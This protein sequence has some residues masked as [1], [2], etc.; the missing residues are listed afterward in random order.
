MVGL[1]A[2]QPSSSPPLSSPQAWTRSIEQ[3][4]AGLSAPLLVQHPDSHRVLVNFDKEIM[5][6][7]R[8]TK[9]MQRFKIGIPEGAELVLLQEEKFK[10]YYNQL[11]YLVNQY[12]SIVSQLPAT[13][14]PL[15]RP[16]LEDMEKK[17]EPGFSLLTWT[18]MNIDG[19]LHRFKQSLARLEELVRKVLDLVDNRVEMNLK[20]IRNTLL[21][22]LPSDKSFS[23]EDF[24][25]T[26]AK[27]Q[28]KQ[29]EQLQVKNEEVRR[30]I[31]DLLQLVKAYPRENVDVLLSETELELFQKHYS[32]LMYQAVL[33]CTQ[34]SL[35]VMKRRLG[36]KI[37]GGF[38]FVERP[39]FDVD[40]ELKV[41]NVV[42]N[43]PLTEIQAA[44]N[45]CAKAILKTSQSLDCWGQTDVATYYDLIVA[46]K[47]IVKS[48]LRMTGSVEGI[49]SHVSEYMHTFNKHEFLWKV[50]LQQA[51]DKFMAENPTLEVRDI[52]RPLLIYLQLLTSSPPSRCLRQS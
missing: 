26:Q 12:D 36:S 8:E 50:D 32:K 14:K 17:I 19:Y 39:I 28:K 22:D 30:S 13:I 47:E 46:D 15:I 43:P 41:P 44:I 34:K 1:V 11:S 25:S 37:S 3:C 48:V 21:V 18:S 20:S 4:K 40:V 10:F 45:T 6:L 5:Q 9:Y 16:H 29:T 33:A 23:Y 35:Q 38:L 51:Y 2:D 31:E 27:F 42:M 7:I 24:I 49:K 52:T